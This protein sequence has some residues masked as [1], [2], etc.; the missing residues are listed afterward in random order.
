MTVLDL[1]NNT[2]QCEGCVDARATDEIRRKLIDVIHTCRFRGADGPLAAAESI[3]ASI[4]DAGLA[5]LP[6]SDVDVIRAAK[7]IVDRETKTGDRYRSTAES[8]MAVELGQLA[9]HLDHEETDARRRD[10]LI[11]EAAAVR[12]QVGPWEEQIGIHRARALYAVGMLQMP[13][14]TTTDDVVDPLT[15]GPF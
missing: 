7:A 1:T 2:H 6:Q 3:A 11:E 15:E 9:D 12:V 8:V 5:A 4:I 14:V 13:E 10:A